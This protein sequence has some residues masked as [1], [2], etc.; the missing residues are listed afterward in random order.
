MQPFG[1]GGGELGLRLTLPGR[2]TSRGRRD[3]AWVHVPPG[4]MHAYRN[5]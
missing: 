4:A 2:A 1:S 3:I 5:V